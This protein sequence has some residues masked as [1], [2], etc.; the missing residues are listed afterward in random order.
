MHI[1]LQP[2]ANEDATATVFEIVLMHQSWIDS[3]VESGDYIK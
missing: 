1:H 3:G 2:K